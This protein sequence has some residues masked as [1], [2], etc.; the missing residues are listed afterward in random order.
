MSDFLFVLPWLVLV[1]LAYAWVKYQPLALVFK[2]LSWL[3]PF[4]E[5]LGGRFPRN[6]L[7][8]HENKETREFSLILGHYTGAHTLLGWSVW[9]LVSITSAGILYLG[10][11]RLLLLLFF[12]PIG[13]Q[14]S[15]TFRRR[16]SI[17]VKNRYLSV[18]ALH[19]DE[20]LVT[21]PVNQVRSVFVHP[22]RFFT[23]EIYRTGFEDPVF[24]H[25][26]GT[27]ARRLEVTTLAAALEPFDI[28]A[29][30]GLAEN[31]EPVPAEA[32]REE[33]PTAFPLRL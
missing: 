26:Y 19:S 23:L 1:P 6:R 28:P 8:H 5:P 21:I 27:H 12:A 7:D 10:E 4:L 25:R 2:G 30:A 18:K 3:L 22:S 29:Y 11:W 9:L 15:F 33:F 31:G 24:T 16:I 20:T 17:E 14:W 32:V 13:M